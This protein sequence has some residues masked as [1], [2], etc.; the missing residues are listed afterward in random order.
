MAKNIV[1][2]DLTDEN[3][4]V[5]DTAV[6]ENAPVTLPGSDA[7]VVEGVDANS[8]LP[9]NAV[10][11][12]DGSVTLTLLYP[13]SLTIKGTDST[14]TESYTT[15]TFHRLN[16]ADQRAIAS[17]SDAM[18]NVVAFARSTRM[19]EAIMNKLFDKLD[20]ADINAAAQVLS[21]FLNSG[22]K[23]GK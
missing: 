12:L 4:T 7:D 3:D 2:L 11:N 1:D 22:R 19:R 16:G 10:Q 14:R 20:A 17:A 15:L 21:S 18:L 8:G 13:Q 9:E 5:R 23:T 6:D